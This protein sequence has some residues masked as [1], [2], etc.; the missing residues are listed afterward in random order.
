MVVAGLILLTNQ[1]ACQNVPL[2]RFGRNGSGLSCKDS[3][4]TLSSRSVL[5]ALVR[6]QRCLLA[7]WGVQRFQCHLHFSL[8]WMFGC[9]PICLRQS[10]ARAKL[11]IKCLW[12]LSKAVLK[13]LLRID[14]A[15]NRALWRT[16]IFHV[17]ADPWV[18]DAIWLIFLKWVDTTN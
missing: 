17:H 4:V 7:I 10:M 18:N 2:S 3:G 16:N 8:Y 13:C 15:G 14:S 12:C 6:D 5:P 9:G 1:L 11:W